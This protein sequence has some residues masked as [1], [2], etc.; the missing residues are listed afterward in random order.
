VE[1]KGVKPAFIIS[2]GGAD[3]GPVEWFNVDCVGGGFKTSVNE[4]AFWFGEEFGGAGIVV[5]EEV[6]EEGDDDS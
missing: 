6:G 2:K 3:I 5:D 1:G 4:S